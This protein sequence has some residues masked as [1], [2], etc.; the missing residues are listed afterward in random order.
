M[1]SVWSEKINPGTEQIFVEYLLCKEFGWLPSQLESEDAQKIQ[2][3]AL[4]MATMKEKEGKEM[5]KMQRD[6]RR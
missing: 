2:L 1:K 5:A 3:F 4:I 6:A